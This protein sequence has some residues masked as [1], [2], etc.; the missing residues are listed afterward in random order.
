MSNKSLNG[1]HVHIFFKCPLLNFCL[2]LPISGEVSFIE[3][4]YGAFCDS[5]VDSPLFQM[6]PGSLYA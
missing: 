3:T 5:E 2:L 4:I 6:D 1:K